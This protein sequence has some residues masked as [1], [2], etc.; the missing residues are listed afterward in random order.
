MLMCVC[1]R[2]VCLSVF[3]P[4]PSQA[5]CAIQ[6]PACLSY[7]IPISHTH[8]HIYIHPNNNDSAATPLLAPMLSSTNN[9]HPATT[10]NGKEEIAVGK[11]GM[12]SSSLASFLDRH[13]FAPHA[14]G[15]IAWIVVREKGGRGGVYICMY[16]H[17]C[18]E[19]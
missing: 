19:E 18:V 6:N 4:P 5:C 9:H 10:T 8:T 13:V 12:A 15:K 14:P 3:P 2:G 1:G 11:G 17:M 7:M 16:I